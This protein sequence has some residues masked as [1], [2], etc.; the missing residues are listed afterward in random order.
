MKKK[1]YI[2]NEIFSETQAKYPHID[3]RKFKILYDGWRQ[4]GMR[5]GRNGQFYSVAWK[6][7]WL[8][9]KDADSL[10]EY[11]GLR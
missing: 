11:I 6:R 2:L 3:I 5:A 4:Q 10:R 9:Q 8:A 1:V 7:G